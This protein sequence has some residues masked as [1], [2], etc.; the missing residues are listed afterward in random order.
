MMRGGRDVRVWIASAFGVVHGLAFFA[1]FTLTD[2]PVSGVGW[3]AAAY[4]S[5]IAAAVAVAAGG[6]VSIAALASAST[7]G[8]SPRRIAVLAGSAAI[9]LAGAAS[10]VS[11]IWVPR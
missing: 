3:A 8:R 7:P 6:V 2:R 9:A 5:G 4:A 1:A 10:F 11:H